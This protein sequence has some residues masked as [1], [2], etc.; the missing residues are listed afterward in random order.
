VRATEEGGRTYEIATDADGR[1]AI[2]LPPGTYTVVAVTVSSG[3]PTAVP[4]AV[5][6]AEGQTLTL[7]L[8]VDTGIR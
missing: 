8:E 1:F 2:D 5:S 4:Q 7:T 3:P 6:V